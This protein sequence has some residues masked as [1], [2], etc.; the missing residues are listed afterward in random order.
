MQLK[1]YQIRTL[2]TFE[3]WLRVL[4]EAEEDVGDDVE[5][6]TRRGRTILPEHRNYPQHAWEQLAAAGELPP[7]AGPYVERYDGAGRPVPHICFKVP[8]GGGKTLLAAAALE[9]LNRPR[10]LVV[11]VMPTRTIYE[12][13]RSALRDKAHPYRQ[14]LERASG[15]RIKLLEKDDRFAP[16]DVAGGLC[17]MLMMLQASNKQINRERMLMNR[18]AARYRPFFPDRDDDVANRQLLADNCD[19]DQ[20]AGGVIHSLTNVLKLL[21]PVVVL[22]EAHKAYGRSAADQYARTISNFNPSIVIELSATP[23]PNISNLLVDIAGTELKAE[24]MIKSPVMV[25]PVPE[26]IDW[27]DTLREA[28]SELERLADEAE[29]LEASEGRYIR[30]IAVVRTELT[31]PKLRDGIRVHVLDVKDYLINDMGVP[32]YAVRIKSSETDELGRE[33]LLAPSSPV[34]WIITKDALKE[35]WDCSFAY[36]L[37]LLDKTQAPTAITQLV[38]RVMRQPDACL[39]NRETL[40]QCY[41]YCWTNDVSKAVQQVKNGLENEGLTGMADDVRG[42]RGAVE[43]QPQVMPRRSEF[44]GVDIFL[45][46]VLHRNG[47]DWQEIDYDEHI[48]PAI[49][50][51]QLELPEDLTANSV[52]QQLQTLALDVDGAVTPSS[53][54]RQLPVDKEVTLSYFTRQLSAIVPNPWYAADIVSNLLAQMTAAGYS[55]A[56]TYDR[57]SD[58]ARKLQESIASQIERMAEQVFIAKRDAGT[59]SFDLEHLESSYPVPQRYRITVSQRDHS[60]QNASQ[61]MQKTLFGR[62][63]ERDFNNLERECAYCL[64][65]H[66]AIQWWHRIVER[67]KHEYFLRGWRRQ[68]IF[69]DFIAMAGEANSKPQLLVFESKGAHLG[70]N[71]DTQYK[72]KV[73]KI[74][75]ETFNAGK[76]SVRMGPVKGMFRLVFDKSELVA[77]LNE[78]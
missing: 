78:L 54:P 29:A 47:K 65:N 53:G 40:D 3:R 46:K 30:P 19:L 5:R 55:D 37:V 74:L 24:E 11:W 59:I 7:G 76:T 61:P 36:M 10:G 52:S 63:L 73:L 66:A 69:P 60:L 27:Q 12:Q 14:S 72:Q 62:A 21:R 57:R 8:T 9:R 1:E 17:V 20:D 70:G 38:G 23:R 34:R 44:K 31:N 58:L 64:D 39:T 50:W 48:L 77:A 43:V 6:R 67:Q 41:V 35:G 51:A 4:S 49:D 18:N 28:H 33:D 68:R 26:H 75:E 13:T 22:D 15:G 32:A 71:D 16:S 25:T 2:E 56:D 42:R 45:P